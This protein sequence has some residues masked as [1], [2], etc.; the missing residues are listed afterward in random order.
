MGLLA[1]S[2]GIASFFLPETMGKPIPQT[3]EQAELFG[4]SENFHFFEKVIIIDVRLSN[5]FRI[6]A[7]EKYA[8][9]PVLDA[10]KHSEVLLAEKTS[11][12]G[13]NY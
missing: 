1:I 6:S 7:K 8:S 12:S 11:I 10:E 9:V 4:K 2:A 3:L 5:N 13:I